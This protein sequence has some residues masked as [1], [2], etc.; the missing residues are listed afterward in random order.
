MCKILAIN[1]S[2]SLENGSTAM[3][4]SAFSDGMQDVGGE[5]EIICASNLDIKACT[6]NQMYCWY[7]A[8]GECCFKDDMQML[9]PKLRAA[10]IL[11]L[12]TTGIHS[13]ARDDADVS[14]PSV[15]FD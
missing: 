2:P 5:V 3:L 14:Q 6:C 15:P 11:V 1:G 4:L 13:P 9:Y 7:K 12:A 8:P 10:D